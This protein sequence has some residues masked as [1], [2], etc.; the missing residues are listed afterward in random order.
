MANP[1]PAA[2]AAAAAAAQFAANGDALAA[3]KAEAVGSGVSSQSN[4]VKS[5]GPPAAAT[6][7]P[8]NFSPQPQTQSH[9]QNPLENQNNTVSLYASIL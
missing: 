2:A 4:L 9:V 5:E 1:F 8:A 7:P 6:L 3:A